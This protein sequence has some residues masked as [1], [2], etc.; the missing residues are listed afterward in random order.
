MTNAREGSGRRAWNRVAFTDWLRNSSHPLFYS[1]GNQCLKTPLQHYPTTAMTPAT[2][3][4]L[5]MPLTLFVLLF[6][7]P[8]WADSESGGSI[9]LPLWGYII[10]V[11][12]MLGICICSN[13]FSDRIYGFLERVH[14]SFARL[15]KKDAN[16]NQ[17]T[18]PVH[19]PPHLQVLPPPPVHSYA[20][21][22][23]D[24]QSSLSSIS[25]AS[26]SDLEASST[27]SLER[28]VSSASNDGVFIAINPL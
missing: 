17:G 13:I 18:I 16:K 6:P 20:E 19:L 7:H 26:R 21:S 22:I 15:L 5:R 3:T 10:I 27:P 8:A 9:S 1:I 24:Y 12:C 11:I 14:R 28:T 4:L 25:Y 2:S 23:A